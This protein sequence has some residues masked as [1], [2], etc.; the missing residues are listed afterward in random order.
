VFHPDD[1]VRWAA[2]GRRVILARVET[3]P[4]DVHGFYAAVGGPHE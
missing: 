2:Q 4:D 1:A 3:K